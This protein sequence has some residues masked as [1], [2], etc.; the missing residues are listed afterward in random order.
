MTEMMTQPYRESLATVEKTK[1]CHGSIAKMKGRGM[2][3]EFL[4]GMMKNR[5]KDGWR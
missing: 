1:E 4:L 5:P 2:D 3:T